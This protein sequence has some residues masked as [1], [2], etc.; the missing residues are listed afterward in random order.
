MLW[1][2]I[3]TPDP[4]RTFPCNSLLLLLLGYRCMGEV[5]INS[6][7]NE[8]AHL[9]CQ[10]PF[11][12]GL[13]SLAVVWA[14]EEKIGKFLQVFKFWNS[15]N[16][17]SIQA[18]QFRGRADLSGNISQGN[19]ELTLTGVTVEDQGV[20][21]CRA[22]NKKNHGDKR[23]ELSVSD[24]VSKP[25]IIDQS[26]KE[27]I[28]LHCTSSTPNVTYKWRQK[29]GNEILSTEQKFI[30]PRPKK[31]VALI[32]TVNDAWSED[33]KSITISNTP[34]SGGNQICII[35]AILMFFFLHNGVFLI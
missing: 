31:K 27:E 33:S 4:N 25:I 29:L 24:R 14:K 26:T 12:Q 21:Y 7:I 28:S 23:V 2:K 17:F 22:A 18:S 3:S 8:D 20:Y 30:A 5:R 16:D 13:E 11:I 34:E 32:C 35:F 6:F 15:Q 1:L 10:F 9:P 19:L